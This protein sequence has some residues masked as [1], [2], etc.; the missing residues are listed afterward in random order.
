[1]ESYFVS[2]G[3][4]FFL[5]FLIMG[6]MYELGLNLMLGVFRCGLVFLYHSYHY[7]DSD[8]IQ[9]LMQVCGGHFYLSV[10]VFYYQ[11]NHYGKTVF[12]VHWS[13]FCNTHFYWLINSKIVYKYS[14]V[15]INRLY[16]II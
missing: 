16:A 14:Q 12:V 6:L 10:Q 8:S 15:N 3:K 5:Y 13:I 1:M 11:F 9:C 7:L 4:I 2:I